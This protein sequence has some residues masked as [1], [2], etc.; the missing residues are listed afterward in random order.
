MTASILRDTNFWGSPLPVDGGQPVPGFEIDRNY[1]IGGGR[2]DHRV[3]SLASTV[4]QPLCEHP[5]RKHAGSHARR[6]RFPSAPSST[7]RTRRAPGHRHLPDAPRDDGLRGR[8]RRCELPG[9]RPPPPRG[10]HRVHLGQDDGLGHGFDFS[11]RSRRIPSCRLRRHPG[12]RQPL[13]RGPPDVRGPL[14]ERRVDAVWGFTL[15]F[16]AR[17]DRTSE[18]LHVLRRSATPPRRRD[19]TADRTRGPAASQPSSG[20]WTSRPPSSTL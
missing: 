8:S 5:P 13:R 11:L 16:G 1:A 20:S 9:R 17:Y 6:G 12:G 19:G 10:R 7:A 4:S 3:Y 2:L 15:T 18:T 14:R